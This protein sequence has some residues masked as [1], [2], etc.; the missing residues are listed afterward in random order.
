MTAVNNSMSDDGVNTD[1][2]EPLIVKRLT[3]V[4]HELSQFL[5]FLLLG[6]STSSLLFQLCQK[7]RLLVL[8]VTITSR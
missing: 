5:L 6:L 8:A 1:A 3:G 7:N 2:S 4:P